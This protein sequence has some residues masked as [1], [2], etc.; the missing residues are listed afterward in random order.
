M[1][2]LL[3]EKAAQA[4][5]K[6]YGQAVNPEQV[7]VN[8][9]PHEFPFDFTIVVFPFSKDS[10]KSPDQKAKELGEALKSSLPEMESFEAVKGFLNLRF[11]DEYWINFLH[12]KREDPSF[13]LL[14]PTGRKVMV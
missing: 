6:L 14:P 13:G 4:I 2:K 5:E 12:A 1:E 9:P 11:S 8:I 7:L 10:K 3:K